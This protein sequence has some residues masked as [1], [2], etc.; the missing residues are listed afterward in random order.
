MARHARFQRAADEAFTIRDTASPTLRFRVVGRIVVLCPFFTSDEIEFDIDPRE[1]TSQAA[2][3]ELLGF[4]RR[5]GDSVGRAV[6]LSY[7]N[8][9][10]HPFISY[11]PG[12]RAFELPQL[13]ALSS[14]TRRDTT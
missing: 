6:M 4:L 13:C 5:V 12:S 8:D 11:E 9:S 10:Q 2:L 7:E 1:A 14:S 3:D